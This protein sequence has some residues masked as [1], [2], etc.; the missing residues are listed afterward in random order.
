[1]KA[2]MK[3]V[4]V[5]G[6]ISTSLAGIKIPKHVFKA[7][8]LDQ[9]VKKAE[10]ENKALAFVLTDQNSNCGLCNNASLEAFSKFKRDAIIVYLNSKKME[11]DYQ[12]LSP[13]VIGGL[14]AKS[15]G[16]YIPKAVITS[17]DQSTYFASVAYEEMKESKSF[18]D[19]INSAEKGL[20]G[21]APGMPE[22][23]E[24]R[25][26]VKNT[27]RFYTGSFVEVTTHKKKG[28]LLVL[29]KPEGKKVHIPTSELATGALAYAHSM[30]AKAKK[31]KAHAA[32]V[33][34]S[35]ESAEGGKIINATFVKLQ[36]RK[37]TLKMQNGKEMTFDVSKLSKESQK[38]A[39]ELSNTP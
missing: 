15:M 36:E 11:V 34:E 7:S 27:S 28:E 22:D 24:Y 19:A 26:I 37:I 16:K 32:I 4:L 1:M 31:A 17:A 6:C 2:L 38:R 13:V 33:E 23:A 14:Q 30:N 25:W 21:Q 29:K 39:R 9:A 35:W 3:L 20:D 12:K 10:E 18:K 8:E 5:L